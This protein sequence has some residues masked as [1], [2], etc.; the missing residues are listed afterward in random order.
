MFTLFVNIGSMCL[1]EYLIDPK[2]SN[3]D[4]G[5]AWG[6]ILDIIW[7]MS[8][9]RFSDN[10]YTWNNMSRLW[11][12][13]FQTGIRL[14]SSERSHQCTKY[15]VCRACKMQIQGQKCSWGT[16]LG[17]LISLLLGTS[18]ETKLAVSC[19][20]GR[21]KIPL[22]TKKKNVIYWSCGELMWN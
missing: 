5:H 4:M 17:L 15:F 3:N 18:R 14:L 6:G 20:T 13:S 19:I 9:S 22:Y 11:F 7:L 8:Q 2:I 16:I 21:I 1:Y 12:K 10:K